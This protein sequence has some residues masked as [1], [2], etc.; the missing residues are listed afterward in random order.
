MSNNG[1]EREGKELID[2]TR[3]F[4]VERPLRTVFEVL[5]TMAVLGGSLWAA[6]MAPAW[7]LQAF[8]VVIA[9][10][11]IV[12]GFIL[13]HD[14][15][16]SALAKG[17][18]LWARLLRAFFWLYG[19]LVL[20]PP[21]NWK[22]THNY[23]HA[24]TAKIVGSHIGSYIVLTTD[25]YRQA[26]PRERLMYKVSRHPLTVLFGY[27][28]IFLWGMCLSSFIRN[29]RKNRSSVTALALHVV[30]LVAITGAFGWKVC[31]TAFVLPLFVAFA[32]GAYLFYAQHNFP[33]MHV[34]PRETWSYTRAA[35]E[36]SSYME[37]GALMRWFTGNI[38]YHHVHHLNPSIPFYRLPEA[39]Y[40]VEELRNP[41][42]TTLRPSDIIACFRLKLWD[43]QR[44]EMVPFP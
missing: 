38:G 17:P 40:G 5:F 29:P 16:H 22:N 37:C 14:V 30:L 11:T 3:P 41:I 18:A 1:S 9:G 25:M 26:T 19:L 43:P 44:N 13:Y 12:R 31:L 23:H 42:K 6:M 8:A 33:G 39:M 24:H 27:A 34:E 2:A 4:A 21:V 7:W 15:F 36:S 32:S 28:T 20:T 10:L 35:L